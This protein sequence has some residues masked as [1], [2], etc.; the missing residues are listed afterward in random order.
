MQRTNVGSE[1][2]FDGNY[3]WN[4]MCHIVGFLGLLS[5]HEQGEKIMFEFSNTKFFYA[6]SY[7]SMVT[8]LFQFHGCSGF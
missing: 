8:A 4:G 6:V 2:S 3:F 7:V 1:R 5:K